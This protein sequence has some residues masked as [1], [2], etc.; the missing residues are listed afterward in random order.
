MGV[1]IKSKHVKQLKAPTFLHSFLCIRFCL[2][3]VL[4]SNMSTSTVSPPSRRAASE[5]PK[6][7]TQSEEVQSMIY[8]QTCSDMWWMLLV[9]RF[10]NALCV[11]TFFQPDEYFQSL[12]PAWQMAFGSD[13]GAWITWVRVFLL[14]CFRIL[15]LCEGVATPAT[16]FFTSVVFRC[17]LLFGR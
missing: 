9:L 6:Q 16:F 5:K 13:S 17:C 10:V 1:S 15:T 3:G 4:L 11:S 12:E 14:K 7:P 2:V 8:S